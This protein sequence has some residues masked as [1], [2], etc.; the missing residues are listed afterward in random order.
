MRVL[1]FGC[2]GFGHVV[3]QLPLARAMR[4]RGDEV[5]FVAAASF[6]PLLHAEGIPLLAE[7]VLSALLTSG[8]LVSRDGAWQVTGHLRAMPPTT[9]TLTMALSSLTSVGCSSTSTM[10][11]TWLLCI[12]LLFLSLVNDMTH[13]RV[14]H[15]GFI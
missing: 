10:T 6:G 13:T 9:L 7:E 11:L 14:D 4:E 3:P 2:P 1:F 12:V 8:R 15:K 5:A